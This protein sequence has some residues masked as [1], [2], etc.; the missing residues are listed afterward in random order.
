MKTDKGGQQAHVPA[1]ELI[2]Q[3]PKWFS[4]AIAA[5][6]HDRRVAYKQTYL[7]YRQWDGP[8]EDAPNIV[9]VH[10][11]GAHARWYDFIAP[12]LTPYY[13]VIAV[14]LPGMGDSGWLETYKRD[15]MAEA[16]ITMIRDAGFKSKPA[17][18]GHSMGGMVSLPTAYTY[19]KELAALMICDFHIRPPEL[20]HEWYMTRDENGDWQPNPTRDTRVYDSFDA[21][22]ARFRLNPE[23]PCA[24]HYIVEYIGTHSLTEVD[25]GWSWKFDPHMFKN[26]PMGEDWQDMYLNMPV[27][28]AAMFGAESHDH[29][30]VSRKELTD[31]MQRLRPDVP[32]FE[33]AGAHHHIMLD[34][35]RAFASSIVQQMQTWQSNGV[36]TD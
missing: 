26:F 23:Q 27:P 20:H 13:N 14:N 12:Q 22:L 28:L 31:Y 6:M 29:E 17:L 35:P 9:L 11:G 21:A 24:N 34:Q 33:I 1:G 7:A 32:H 19:H 36:F 2:E 30:D 16:V 3:T 18:I 5:P 15:I 10:G 25:G 4:D 8:H